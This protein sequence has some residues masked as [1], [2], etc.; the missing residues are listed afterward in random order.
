V[1]QNELEAGN[2]LG[3]PLKSTGVVVG[4][5]EL[6]KLS[7]GF[8]VA[9]VVPP[10]VGTTELPLPMGPLDTSDGTVAPTETNAGAGLRLAGDCE[11]SVKSDTGLPLKLDGGSELGPSLKLIGVVVVSAVGKS[12][13][14]LSIGRSDTSERIG[15]KDSRGTAVS[16]G[17]RLTGDRVLPFVSDIVLPVVLDGCSES[18]P[19]TEVIGFAELLEVKGGVVVALVVGIGVDTLALLL[20]MGRT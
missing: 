1:G 20:S 5:A 17:R 14:L 18:R 16:V 9:A 8:V 3:T 13:L 2:E 15:T 11:L 4:F 7:V 19:S 6:L 10:A 12:E